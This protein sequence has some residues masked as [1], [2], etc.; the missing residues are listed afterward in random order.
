[1]KAS[2]SAQQFNLEEQTPTLYSRQSLA[3]WYL[4]IYLSL[5]YFRAVL[6]QTFLHR[7]LEQIEWGLYAS[8][9]VT[10][11]LLNKAVNFGCNTVK[12]EFSMCK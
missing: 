10:Y 11:T 2:V 4:A 12:I 9:H 3:S 6:L 1:M 5:N 7:F 8:K